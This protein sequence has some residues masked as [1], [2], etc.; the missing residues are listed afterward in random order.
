MVETV[1]I[2]LSNA[3]LT[4][5][6]GKSLAQSLYTTPLTITL[7][8]ELGAGKTTFLQGFLQGLG[9]TDPVTS[10]TYALEQRY[11]SSVGTIAHIDLYRLHEKE[12]IRFLEE[13]D[14]DAVLRCIEWPERSNIPGDIRIHLTED[15]AKHG[16]ALTLAFNDIPLPLE[17]TIA[18]WREDVELPPHIVDHCEAVATFSQVLADYL[19]SQ[20]IIVRKKALN[21][22]AKLHDLIRFVDFKETDIPD[23]WTTYKE[24][25]TDLG[26]EAACSAFLKEHGFDALAD[27]VIAHGL[28]F[29]PPN[30]VTIEQKLLYYADKRVMHDKVVTVQE[31]FDDF[32]ERYASGITT[33]ESKRWLEEVLEIERELFP[34]GPIFP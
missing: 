4:K 16:R 10:P 5:L 26:H 20:G 15:T 19:L 7:S 17:A 24:R 22:A 33:Q 32:Q 30:R 34:S 1:S 18:L 25:Y 28:T 21:T 27:I 6:A 29:S 23:I 2:W 13:C 31:R 12:A 11:E 14:N 8:G 9:V 3:E